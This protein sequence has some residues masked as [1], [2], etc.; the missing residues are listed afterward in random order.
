MTMKSFGK[1][2]IIMNK[3]PCVGGRPLSVCDLEIYTDHFKDMLSRFWFLI[4]RLLICLCISD[5][6]RCP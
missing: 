3:F 6:F 2:Y 4:P 5:T 1:A